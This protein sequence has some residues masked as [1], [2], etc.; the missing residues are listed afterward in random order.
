VRPDA[1]VISD[2]STI[3]T[4]TTIWAAG[5]QP[6]PFVGNLDLQ[7]DH[8]GKMIVDQYLRVRGRSGVYA[9]GDCTTIQDRE[10][11][12]PALA[13]AAEQQGKRAASN[14]AAEI[15][16][17][18]PAAFRYRPVGQLV[19]LG[20]GSALVDIL[21][22]KLGGLLG[23]LSGRGSTSTN[24]A[25]TSTARMSS[26][27]GPSTTSPVR[28]PPNSWKIP[29]RKPSKPELLKCRQAEKLER[30]SSFR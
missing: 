14:L 18:S 26:P 6:P 4:R 10:P 3:P 23:Q 25:T 5:I 8:R 22:V 21:G 19:D 24:S 20:E 12:V 28:A 29:G 15:L 16:G 1:V 2:G 27:T 13:Q 30:S 9:V 11:P 7:R 17:K